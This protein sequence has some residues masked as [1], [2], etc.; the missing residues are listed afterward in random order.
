ME[1]ERRHWTATWRCRPTCDRFLD[2]AAASHCLGA[3][4]TI[5]APG[6]GTDPAGSSALWHPQLAKSLSHGALSSR[7]KRSD[8]TSRLT[9]MG[10]R[11]LCLFPL[12]AS[13]DV[14]DGLQPPPLVARGWASNRANT[15]DPCRRFAAARVTYAG[16]F[17][18]L[19]FVVAGRAVLHR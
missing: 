15:R 18:L 19:L 9:V 12:T 11:L 3:A 14:S 10:P 1:Q 2:G 7:K 5:F 8:T 6:A 13:P 4:P 16:L 17:E